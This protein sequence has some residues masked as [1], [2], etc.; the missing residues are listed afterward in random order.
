MTV[1][2]AARTVGALALLSAALPANAAITGAALVSRR[3]PRPPVPLH[4]RRTVLV[5]GGKM[6]KALELCRAFHDAGHRVVLVESAKYRLTGHRFSQAVDAFHTVPDSSADDYA[7]ALL[8]IV[9]QEQVDVYVPV[10]SPAS[11]VPDAR[12]K[13]L[14]SG[15]CEVLHLDA[16]DLERLDDKYQFFRAARP[17]HPIAVVHVVE[18]SRF[19]EFAGGD[20]FAHRSIGLVVTVGV[21][22]LKHDAGALRGIDHRLRLVERGR[23]RLFT[24]HVF[25]RIACI[26][27]LRGVKIRRRGDVH[28]VDDIGSEHFAETRERTS[29]I[30]ACYGLPGGR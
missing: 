21:S 18:Q 6:T 26:D 5:S 24:Q 3:P 22:N 23:H 16:G 13:P 30:P 25:A 15:R 2:D 28:R 8:R 7:E 11:S 10:C 1:R 29:T 17:V 14:L 4:G 9:E 19:A 20:E 27:D 12:A